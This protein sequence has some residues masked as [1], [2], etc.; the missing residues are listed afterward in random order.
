MKNLQLLSVLIIFLNYSAL[1]QI[2]IFSD[3]DV[4]I[5]NTI[6]PA[7][8]FKLHVQGNSLF[9]DLLFT[10]APTSSSA[11][12]IRGAH[13]FSDVN[14]PDYTWFNYDRTGFF[15]PDPFGI[16]VSI[17]GNEVFRF[18]NNG[19]KNYG[20]AT[21]ALSPNSPIS[22]A[23][24][25]RGSNIHSVENKPDFTWFN[26]DITGFFH[27]KDG[28][29]GVS[30]YGRE[31]MRVTDFGNLLVGGTFD[32]G[33]FRLAITAEKGRSAFS[34]VTTFVGEQNGYAHVSYVD[35]ELTKNWV[36][37]YNGNENFYVYGNG[38]AWCQYQFVY[39]DSVLKENIHQLQS[40]K[41]KLLSLRG[42]SY[43]LKNNALAKAS[44]KSS[45]LN[46]KIS[47]VSNLTQIGLIAEEV[48]RVFPEVVSTN[49]KGIKGIAYQNLVAVIIEAF[50]EQ[51][52]VIDSLKTVIDQCCTI[53]KYSYLGS[54]KS[55]NSINEP[56]Q[57]A[58][59]DQNLPN[60]FSTNTEIRFFIPEKTNTKS[61]LIFNLQG[62]LL[63]EYSINGYGEQK[64][65]IN[66]N[67]FN[68]GM[69][70]YS[71]VVDGK[72]ID[73]KRMILTK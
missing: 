5:G 50:K 68:P 9:S 53:S 7:S 28:I 36:V 1:A 46:E 17:D 32:A 19:L 16:G 38:A 12:F 2:K 43:N 63:K 34:T 66:G 72:E 56:T 26:D 15:H 31:R 47:N 44:G 54:E 65:N 35:N 40:A 70:L 37:D 48:E 39:S 29:I 23:A 25:I 24:Y 67:E 22:S 3:G 69:Y 52:L 73:T 49:D 45:N 11:A 64:I 6:P 59:L 62:N 14:T 51:N 8:N 18:Y 60:P 4:I 55:E 58:R 30:T 10:G 27:P 71:L 21:F 13:T 41:T 57:I 42:V 20:N 33:G 61:L